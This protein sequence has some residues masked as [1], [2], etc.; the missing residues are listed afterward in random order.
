MLRLNNL[1]SEITK[2]YLQTDV[3]LLTGIECGEWLQRL[4]RFK[5]QTDEKTW[6]SCGKATYKSQ[7]E[8][9]SPPSTII[10]KNYGY[11]RSLSTPFLQFAQTL[12]WTVS[13]NSEP[14]TEASSKTPSCSCNVQ[15]PVCVSVGADPRVACRGGKQKL[16][17]YT[18]PQL[19]ARLWGPRLIRE[20]S[21]LSGRNSGELRKAEVW[22]HMHK[23]AKRGLT[24]E[25]S[26]LSVA[27]QQEDVRAAGG[28]QLEPSSQGQR[29]VSDRS[30]D[31]K[32]GSPTAQGALPIP[33]QT[34][35]PSPRTRRG[36]R[37]LT[38]RE[39]THPRG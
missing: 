20:E 27:D 7:L 2:K 10:D 3:D 15:R 8:E 13:P 4:D 30:L 39:K 1:L 35:Y 36:T 17:H 16:P 12:P 6:S 23:C 26:F 37:R 33:E 22:R 21:G 9:Q 18:K 34:P 32:E 25:C 28:G 14:E 29:R 19:Q 31:C 5:P 11:I 24:A 38:R